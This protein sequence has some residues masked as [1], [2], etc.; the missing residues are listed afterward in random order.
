MDKTKD[1]I[2]ASGSSRHRVPEIKNYVSLD[3]NDMKL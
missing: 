3:P 2:F 1:I